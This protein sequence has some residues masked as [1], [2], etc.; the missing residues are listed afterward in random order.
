MVEVDSA[1]RVARRMQQARVLLRA[2]SYEDIV[3]RPTK[4]MFGQLIIKRDRAD[5]IPLML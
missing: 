3:V 1:T 4:Q 5:A 2:A